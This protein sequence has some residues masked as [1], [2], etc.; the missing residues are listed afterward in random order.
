MLERFLFGKLKAKYNQHLQFMKLAGANSERDIAFFLQV[1][2]HNNVVYGNYIFM[3]DRKDYMDKLIT[4]GFVEQ[5]PTSI[6]PKQNL[7]FKYMYN[8]NL[9]ISV[10]VVPASQWAAL[11]SATEVMRN[12][13][14][15]NDAEFN[16]IRVIYEALVSFEKPGLSNPT[17]NK[18]AVTK[19]YMDR[20][21]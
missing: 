13:Y 14:T 6:P 7:R 19:E 8:E 20:T 15:P 4:I 9:N 3:P 21:A 12:I 5:A 18:D 11:E 2:Q 10:H 17:P 1:I 16:A